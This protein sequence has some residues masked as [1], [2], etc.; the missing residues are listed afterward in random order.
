MKERTHFACAALI[1]AA[2]V[3]LA[4]GSA[5]AEQAGD[6]EYTVAWDGESVIIDKYTGKGGA[7]TIPA[8]IAGLPVTVIGNWAFAH[9][10]GLTR[11]LSPKALP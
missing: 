1:T 3:C 4:A 8:T 2:L 11:L 5:W 7:V 9:Y 10:E 6:W